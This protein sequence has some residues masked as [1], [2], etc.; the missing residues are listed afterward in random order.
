MKFTIA[1]FLSLA[2]LAIAAPAPAP[3]NANR[4]VPN[5]KCCTPNTSLKQ[6]VCNVNGQSGRCVPSGANNC[7]SFPLLNFNEEEANANGCDRW[8]CFDLYRGLEAGLQCE[9]S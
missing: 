7:M 3:Q 2:A 5:G 4:P 6:D 1:A 8:W 9:C